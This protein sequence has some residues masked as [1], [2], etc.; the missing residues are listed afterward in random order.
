MDIRK[1]SA[2]LVLTKSKHM[3]MG[4]HYMKAKVDSDEIFITCVPSNGNVADLLFKKVLS[5]Q[6]H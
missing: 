3:N 1:A 4:Y 5:K 6:K 2:A